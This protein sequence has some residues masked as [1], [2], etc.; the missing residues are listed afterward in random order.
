M[1]KLKRKHWPWEQKTNS[2][3]EPPWLSQHQKFFWHVCFDSV[4]RLMN[5]S[6]LAVF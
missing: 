5:Q 6:R 4:F 1:L 3:F 2:R